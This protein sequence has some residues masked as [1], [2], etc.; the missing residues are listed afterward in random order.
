MGRFAARGAVSPSD[1]GAVRGFRVRD[2]GRDVPIGSGCT[3]PPRSLAPGQASKMSRFSLVDANRRARFGGW[4]DAFHQTVRS[5]AQAWFEKAQRR[6]LA[7]TPRTRQLRS[8]SRQRGGLPTRTGDPNAGI[9]NCQQGWCPKRQALE[10]ERCRLRTPFPSPPRWVPASRSPLPA[11]RSAGK[12]PSVS[13]AACA[14]GHDGGAGAHRV[15]ARWSD[16]TQRQMHDRIRCRSDGGS[17][18]RLGWRF[19]QGLAGSNT[20]RFV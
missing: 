9:C 20:Q 17:C 2:L 12:K 18:L 6:R 15:G 11:R 8:E 14:V 13:T 10:S 7:W 5:R 1:G 3:L 4:G 16:R 19:I